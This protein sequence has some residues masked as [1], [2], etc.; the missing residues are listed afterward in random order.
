MSA[1]LQLLQYL[2][3]LRERPDCGLDIKADVQD[4]YNKRIQNMFRGTTWMS[5]CNSWY[6]TQDGR[7]T[8]LWPGFSWRY[9]LMTR[10]FALSDYRVVAADSAKPALSAH[11]PVAL[12][13]AELP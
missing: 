1:N 4:Q 6:L 2:Q 13:C 9:R 5:G 12:D 7:N 11:E 3:T 10:R 8:T